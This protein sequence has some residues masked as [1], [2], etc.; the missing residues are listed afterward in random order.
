MGFLV[1]LGSVVPYILPGIGQQAVDATTA[2]LVYSLEP[3]F[4]M[5]IAVAFFTEPQSTMKVVGGAIVLL[6]QF[7]GL[8][9]R[10]MRA[11]VDQPAAP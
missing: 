3:L 11:G 6:A 8:S 4:A 10:K 7:V 5:A 2:A 1:L 9:R